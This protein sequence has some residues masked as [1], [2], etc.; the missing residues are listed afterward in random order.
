MCASLIKAEVDPHV[1]SNH[2]CENSIVSGFSNAIKDS[3]KELGVV[4]FLAHT[5]TLSDEINEEDQWR[6]NVYKE[7]ISFKNNN[8]IKPTESGF[9]VIGGFSPNLDLFGYRFQPIVLRRLLDIDKPT[10]AFD[11]V[12]TR[13]RMS[14][15]HSPFYPSARSSSWL[16]VFSSPGPSALRKVLQGVDESVYEDF[17]N[18]R[19]YI[20]IAESELWMGE[21]DYNYE[22]LIA[23]LDYPEGKE[24]P[25]EVIDLR[26]FSDAVV[27]DFQQILSVYKMSDP[28]FMDSD[29][30]YRELF[31]NTLRTDFG[32]DVARRVF[33]VETINAK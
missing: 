22:Y 8:E 6:W 31:I 2:L 18:E 29:E 30:E 21:R 13:G 24:L 7:T 4:Y 3:K 11:F 27:L 10:L 23:C 1:S 9:T 12:E 5:D 20:D 15:S 33:K 14:E 32:R 26:G 17:L 28:C 16:I 25:A 19:N